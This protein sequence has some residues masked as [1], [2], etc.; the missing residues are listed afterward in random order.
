MHQK[1]MNGRILTICKFCLEDAR[2]SLR[3]RNGKPINKS[4]IFYILLDLKT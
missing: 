1:Y 4:W 2:K 3:L